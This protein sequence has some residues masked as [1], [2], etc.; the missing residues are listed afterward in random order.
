MD[1]H[2]CD[3]A[4]GSGEMQWDVG[5]RSAR[6]SINWRVKSRRIFCVGA[7]SAAHLPSIPETHI[8]LELFVTQHPPSGFRIHI[9]MEPRDD[10]EPS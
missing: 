2:A 10:A 7:S 4:I 6:N 5:K 9:S 3:I 8:R 1:D